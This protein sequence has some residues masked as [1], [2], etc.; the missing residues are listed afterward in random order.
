MAKKYYELRMDT[1]LQRV[2]AYIKDELKD[3]IVRSEMQQLLAEN[4][5]WQLED[6]TEYYAKLKE[7]ATLILAHYS[8]PGEE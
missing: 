4:R 5:T 3:A 2:V 8:V 6:D 7:A 1:E